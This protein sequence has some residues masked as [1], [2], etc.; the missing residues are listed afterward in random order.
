MDIIGKEVNS[1]FAHDVQDGF[2]IVNLAIQT[3]QEQID[4]IRAFS[5][6]SDAA[7]ICK[8]YVVCRLRDLNYG[9]MSGCKHYYA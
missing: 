8:H 9:C 7:Q 3:L 4:A 1:E 2:K 5:K 6:M